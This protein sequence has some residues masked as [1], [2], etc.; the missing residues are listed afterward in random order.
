MAKHVDIARALKDRDYF[1]SLSEEEKEMV[2]KASPVGG[3]GLHDQ[4]LDSVSGGLAGGEGLQSTT[5]STILLYCTCDGSP[6]LSTG[7][8]SDCPCGC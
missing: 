3:S 2:R 8:E 7:T 5:T 1:N 4:D 6:A